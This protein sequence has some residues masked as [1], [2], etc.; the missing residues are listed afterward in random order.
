[1]ENTIGIIKK[2]ILLED[3]VKDANGKLRVY[4]YGMG[5]KGKK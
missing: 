1:M 3:A 5:E 4:E 2:D